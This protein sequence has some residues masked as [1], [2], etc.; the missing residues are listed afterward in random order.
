MYSTYLSA[1]NDLSGIMDSVYNTVCDYAEH[2]PQVL[3]KEFRTAIVH[4]PRQTGKSRA[5]VNFYSNQECA[6]LVVPNRVHVV[7]M[8]QCVN[9]VFVETTLSK[10]QSEKIITASKLLKLLNEYDSTL[11]KETDIFVLDIMGS[12]EEG[13]LISS[14]TDWLTKNKRFKSKVFIL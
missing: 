2:M 6:I 13:E 5:A 12:P 11:L 9:H 10:S 4:G 7:S 1:L 3:I 14:L 8:K